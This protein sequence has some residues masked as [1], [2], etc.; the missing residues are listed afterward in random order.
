M[1]QPRRALDHGSIELEGMPDIVGL[2]VR[3]FDPDRDYPAMADL[4][5]RVNTHDGVDWLPSVEALVNEW[6]H[7]DGFDPV[8]DVLVA[9]FD[10]ALVASVD[11]TWR[12]RGGSVHQGV[13]VLVAPD[14]RGRG[15]GTAL[16]RWA[17]SKAMRELAD[18]GRG[19]DLGLPH[20]FA[21]WAELE[22]P[23]VLP[24]ATAAG[25]HVDGYG[26]M[27]TRPLS[28]PIAPVALPEGLELRPVRVED[29]RAIWD[30]DVEAF[31]DHRDPDLRTDADYEGFFAQPDLD[32]ALWLVA[33][34]GDRV[35]GSVLNFVFAR[36]NE[37]LGVRRGWLEHVS[38]RRPWRRRGLASALI[39]MSLEL[40]RDLGLEE[41]ALGADAENLTGAVRLYEAHGFRRVRTAAR[42]RKAIAGFEAPVGDAPRQV[43]PMPASGDA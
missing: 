30:A 41:A 13:T 33:W 4:I 43:A 31:Q 38:V 24:W 21:G 17:E 42:Y 6:T 19:A 28:E 8:S 27:M 5:E 25:Y 9:E 3:A 14:L 10:R 1:S 18:G 2:S 15:I 36:E 12:V 7:T 35:A 23:E 26:V 11:L 34:D 39:T 32:T 16:R 22:I 40:L 37:R 20:V 29:H